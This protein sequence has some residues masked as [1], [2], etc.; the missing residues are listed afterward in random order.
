MIRFFTPKYT[1]YQKTVH[2]NLFTQIFLPPPP[3]Y[4]ISMGKIGLITKITKKNV[5]LRGG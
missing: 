5:F 3:P 1:F 2:R 4:V